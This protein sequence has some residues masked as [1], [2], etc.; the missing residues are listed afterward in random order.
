MHKIGKCHRYFHG[1]PAWIKKGKIENDFAGHMISYIQEL[2]DTWCHSKKVYC[3]KNGEE[4]NTYENEIFFFCKADCLS[5][6][7][8]AIQSRYF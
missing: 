2:N 8:Q 1:L 5:K 6:M 4:P 7:P 3:K